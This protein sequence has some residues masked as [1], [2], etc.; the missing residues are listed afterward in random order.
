M[1][2]KWIKT[3]ALALALLTATVGTAAA[4]GAANEMTV[5]EASPIL[6]QLVTLEGTLQ[7]SELEGGYEVD[8]WMLIGDHAMF[9][10]LSGQKVWILGSEDHGPSTVMAKRV[11]VER[12]ERQVAM[13]RALPKTILVNGQEIKAD[14]V[15]YMHKG[16]LMLPLRALV[17]AAGGTIEWRQETFS[18]YVLM[19]DRTAYFTVGDAKA[20]MYLHA[21]RYM[22]RNFLNMDQQ[23]VLV[24]G[25]MFVSADAASNV[26]GMN[27]EV[28]VDEAVLSLRFPQYHFD[29]PNPIPDTQLE[30]GYDLKWDGNR[31]EISGRAGVPDLQFQVLLDGK[32]IAQADT[33]VKE[34]HYI[35]NVLVEGGQTQAGKLELQI[36]DPI[37]G[38][39]LATTSV[40]QQ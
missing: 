10:Q 24:G 29:I 28:T 11:R 39:V 33:T 16:T 19:G 6:A 37:S 30:L 21:A 25:R 7:K 38:T 22:G 31:L 14:Q 35:A 40:G 4:A 1:N 36:I 20:E 13:N 17:E 32:V 3:T 8:G 2:A 23:V 27:E 34:G 18:A 5:V 15:Q 12:I 26:L 9:E